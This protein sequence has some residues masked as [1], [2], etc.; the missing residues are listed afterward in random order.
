LKNEPF[1]AILRNLLQVLFYE[2]LK[3]T[4]ITLTDPRTIVSV[5]PAYFKKLPKMLKKRQQ[6]LSSSTAK[7]TTDTW[8]Q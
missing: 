6:I 7:T 8:L 5:V 4:F 3:F 2:S 1:S